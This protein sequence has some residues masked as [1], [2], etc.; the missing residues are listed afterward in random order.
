MRTLFCFLFLFLRFAL[1]VKTAHGN[2]RTRK[3]IDH[4]YVFSL[5][6]DG[7]PEHLLTPKP[8]GNTGTKGAVDLSSV[9]RCRKVG[10][11]LL[12]TRS[13]HGPLLRTK[14]DTDS[15]VAVR[16]WPLQSGHRASWHHEFYMYGQFCER[17][18]GF[19]CSR[20]CIHETSHVCMILCGN[21]QG[22]ACSV[23]P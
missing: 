3:K 11:W 14:C 10:T 12:H 8:E 19:L 23:C 1:L 6:L 20:T 21:D 13:Q 5:D 22:H 15:P 2:Q 9:N 17:W 7:I 16:D 18:P 4:Y